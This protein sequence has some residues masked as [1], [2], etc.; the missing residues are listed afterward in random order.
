MR[1]RT[2][3]IVT[4]AVVSAALAAGSAAAIASTTGAKPGGT[5]I[6]ASSR[7]P[8]TMAIGAVMAVKMKAERSRWSWLPPVPGLAARPA[9][10]QTSAARQQQPASRV[11]LS[12]G[13]QGG[14]RAVGGITVR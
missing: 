8:P 13:R 11:A 5:G 7:I 12:R 10:R 9:S 6:R 1:N 3:I 2:R 4:A 14:G